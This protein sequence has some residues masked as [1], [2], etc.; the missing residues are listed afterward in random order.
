MKRVREIFYTDELNDEFSSA[1]IKARKID[2]SYEYGDD[3]LWWNVR[4]VAVYRFFALPIAWLYLKIVWRHKIVNKAVMRPYAR[5]A[6]FLYGNHTSAS[7]DPLVPA[8]VGFPRAVS[9][10]VH[11]A[12]VSIPVI[13]RL[14]PFAGALP[15]PDTFRAAKNFFSALALR[16]GKNAP[17]A[18]YP[19][20]HIWPYCTK[21][22]NF[23]DASFSYPVRFGTP[24]F[25]FTSTYKKSRF[26]RRPKIVTYVDGPFFADGT[27]G[28]KE[29][30]KKLRDDVHGAMTARSALNTAEI[31]RYTKKGEG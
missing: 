30:R 10:I 20:A 16:V 23:P 7:F 26:F 29:A 22:R 15:L 19:E 1:V 12:N 17:I 11:P 13:G 25:S 6:M 18:I 28:E 24:V 21:I 4:H 8:F 3:S 27:L 5:R 2:G 31:V 9:V 14:L